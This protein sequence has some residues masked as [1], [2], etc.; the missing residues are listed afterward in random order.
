MASATTIY[1]PGRMSSKRSRALK[2]SSLE[3][4][5]IPEGGS[6]S[7]SLSP[8]HVRRSL[9]D[10]V[11]CALVALLLCT[12][13]VAACV[14]LVYVEHYYRWSF[15][16][17]VD[18]NLDY[19]PC[20]GGVAPLANYSRCLRRGCKY[21]ST[22]SGLPA[23][24]FPEGYG[25]VKQ[26]AAKPHADSGGFNALLTRTDAPSLFG[27]EF[28]D[29]V[30]NVSFIT[31]SRLRFQIIPKDNMGQG[32]MNL[33]NDGMQRCSESDAG[34]EVFH[35]QAEEP[36]GVTVKRKGNGTV[37]FDTNLPGTLLAQQFLQISTRLPTADVFGLG[38]T[39]S[40]TTLK[41][42]IN[43]RRTSFFSK[44]GHHTSSE[45]S[46]VHPFY[47]AL[48]EDGKAIGVFMRNSNPMDVLMQPEKVITFRT[49]GG[50]LDFDIFL[51]E[52]PDGVV[53]AF[54]KL[55]GRPAM[56]P[57]WALG[58]HLSLDPEFKLSDATN[59]VR[60]LNEA[61]LGVAALHL[62]EGFSNGRVATEDADVVRQIRALRQQM[63]D[64][65]VKVM[66]RADPLL[67]ASKANSLPLILKE[68]ERL[69]N[70]EGATFVDFTSPD[71]A[72]SWEQS[73][74]SL[75]DTIG[76]DGLLLDLNEPTYPHEENRT[77]TGCAGNK[78]NCPPYVVGAQCGKGRSMFD[79]SVCGDAKQSADIHYNLH[80][81]YGY[82]HSEAT[83]KGLINLSPG[84]RPMILSRATFSGSGSFG[85][86][87]FEERRC[88]WENLRKAIVKAIEFSMFGVPLVGGFCDWTEAPEDIRLAWH[89]VSALLPLSVSKI[90]ATEVEEVTRVLQAS[91][92]AHEARARLLPYMYT[93]FHTAHET[94]S[95]VLRGLFYEFP[96]DAN[97][98][99]VS[100]QFMWG[101]AILVS[102]RVE[103][104]ENVTAYFPTGQWC[105]FYTGEATNLKE[106][107]NVILN[108]SN[109][110][111]HVRGGS[112]IP[113]RHPGEER[114][115][116]QTSLELF[117]A[118]DEH[119]EA[120]G[121]LFWDD[122]ITYYDDVEKAPKIRFNFTLSKESESS[123]KLSITPVES[124][125]QGRDKPVIA[126]VTM[127]NTG[128][129]PSSVSL[130]GARTVN[131]SY[132]LNLK[133]LKLHTLFLEV[134]P[135]V[136]SIE[137]S[138]S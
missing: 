84:R 5:S 132:D 93:V 98:V 32:I 109:V 6:S 121:T 134:G 16:L 135:H 63:E 40:K 94:G 80:N 124:S 86:H 36:F 118:P 79:E 72:K 130:D 128:A 18:C 68:A 61:G 115:L 15:P 27:G 107:G 90:P 102:P 31:P 122:G 33:K 56:P 19:A 10:P 38:G 123:S 58:Q 65:G 136:I 20:A 30:V 52:N 70:T 41:H 13:V 49:T 89:Q 43:W 22:S 133:V 106:G 8:G 14:V 37:V 51:E 91:S 119:G 117:V 101:P 138:M 55:V 66:L 60:K 3:L 88:S 110:P 129:A 62:N 7:S 12:V 54:A 64:S 77:R 67:P 112:I 120:T 57:L 28:N 99:N 71:A 137:H 116:T 26:G 81:L 75:L 87:W 48:E 97:A 96:M 100:Y 127:C 45:Y 47:L 131:T 35:S 69:N 126:A 83:W 1:S 11:L 85:G 53:R 125:Y 39:S 113:L 2:E 104:V 108:G 59:L 9:R 82:H 78:W 34:Y 50:V 46:G 21:V 111:I 105:S 44:R 103:Q 25:Y 29:V 23:C 92:T 42:D 114:N 95:A 4:L 73:C 74:R 17:R 76:F 24:F